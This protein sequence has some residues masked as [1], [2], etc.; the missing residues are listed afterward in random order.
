[1]VEVGA[2][3]G[4]HVRVWVMSRGRSSAPLTAASSPVNVTSCPKSWGLMSTLKVVVVLS[5]LTV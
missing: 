2:G 5:A 4:V 3:V 1:V